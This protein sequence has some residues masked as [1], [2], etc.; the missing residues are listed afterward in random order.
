MYLAA[1]LWLKREGTVR[2]KW[3]VGHDG[4]CVKQPCL[5][6]PFNTKLMGLRLVPRHTLRCNSLR[7]LIQFF[8]KSKKFNRNSL[9]TNL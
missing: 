2:L 3:A 1:Y 8:L 4:S 7:N 9:M 6:K 5:G